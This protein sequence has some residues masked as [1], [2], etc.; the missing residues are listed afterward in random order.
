MATPGFTKHEDLWFDDG[1]V[2]LIAE[3]TGF[4]LFRGLLSRQSEIFRGMFQMPQSEATAAE[5]YEGC[6]VVR[7][8]EDG[9]EEWVEVLGILSESSKSQQYVARSRLAVH[10]TDQCQCV[11][12]DNLILQVL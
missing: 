12:T 10:V 5:M 3:N 4:R 1:N 2:V 6:P 8:V 7:V 11:T 9:A